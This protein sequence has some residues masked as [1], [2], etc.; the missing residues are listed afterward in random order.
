MQGHRRLT[1]K[2]LGASAALSLALTLS[3]CSTWA[4]PTSWFGGDEPAAKDSPDLA[5]L[6]D[7]PAP[8]AEQQP[9][10][11]SLS[12]DLKHSQYSA[13]T[14]RAGADTSAPPPP[15]APK[16]ETSAAPAAV[17]A[18][19]A[20]AP[21]PQAPVNADRSAFAAPSGAAVVPGA[22]P[23]A[24][25]A[26]A[27]PVA[28]PAPVADAPVAHP[29]KSAAKTSAHK[30][31]AAVLPAGSVPAVPPAGSSVDATPSV[32]PKAAQSA[33]AAKK[34]MKVASAAAAPAPVSKADADLGFQPSSAP[35]LDPSVADF[36]P[37]A[38]MNQYKASASL[39]V[40][41]SATRTAKAAKTS[42]SVMPADVAAA[43]GA[44]AAVLYFPGDIVTL[45]SKAQELV[46]D[47][48]ARFRDAGGQGMIR[49]VG[50]ASSRTPDMP[51]EKHLALIYKKSETR[52]KA[53]AAALR[54]A[55]VPAEKITVEAVGDSQPVYYESMPKGEDGNRR[56]EIFLQG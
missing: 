23:D 25:P 14:L 47:V 37:P 4:D 18:P 5:N 22:L 53:V 30:K 26:P 27:A 52:A 11:D 28:A 7:K 50:H 21:V 40:P 3:A 17:S 38:I 39:P 16:A 56:V 32:P 29:A 31:P 24:T 15:A 55:G 54:R 49:V 42:R 51:V 8:A 34:T 36:V 33:R 46:R 10:K 6:P 35:P 12:A 41:K 45:N 19:A 20:P 43:A 48:V 9:L 44:A 1:A 2:L 13:E